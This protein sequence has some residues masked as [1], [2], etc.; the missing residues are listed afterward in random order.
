MPTI[1]TDRGAAGEGADGVTPGQVT[2][3]RNCKLLRGG[4]IV[5]DDLWVKHGK[6]IDPESRFWEAMKSDEVEAADVVVDCR[7]MLLSPGFIDVQLNGAFGVDFTNTELTMG[8]VDKVSEGILKHGVTSYCPTVVTSSPAVY[9]KVLPL[10]APAPGGAAKACSLGAHLEGPFICKKKKGAHDVN[11][12][13]SPVEGFKSLLDCYG[14]EFERCTKIVT[15]APELPGAVPSADL[16]SGVI[17]AVSG[18]ASRKIVASLGHTACDLAEANRAVTE[19][20]TMITHM[21]NAMQSFHHRD[22][23]LVGVLGSDPKEETPGVYYGIICDEIHCHPASVR[24]AYNASPKKVVLVTDAMMAMGLP[25]GQYPLGTMTVDITDRACIA[26]TDTLAGAIAPMDVCMRNF[27]KFTGCSV[28]E[29]LEAASLHPAEVAGVA[30]QKGT[31]EV[32]SDADVIFLDEELHV[33]A[34][35]VGG[36]M[37]WSN[38]DHMNAFEHIVHQDSLISP[39]R[40]THSD[41]AVLNQR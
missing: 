9:N 39:T 21:F 23:G 16:G 28:V 35:Y 15:L 33:Q 20:A 19:G 11:L 37:A 34:C 10:L 24:I 32:G 36:E 14:Q 4:E 18:L 31:L 29:A 5:Q 8:Q 7:G 27:M 30:P 1:R 12:I 22:P 40:L 3:F 17:D 13:R 38:L 2:K 6:I 26:G 41:S 25:P